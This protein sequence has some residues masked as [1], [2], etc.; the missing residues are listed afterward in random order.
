MGAGIAAVAA[1]VHHRVLLY[2][3]VEG[4]AAR[5]RDGIAAD[6]AALVAR[7]KLSEAEAARRLS[8]IEVVTDLSGLAPAELVIEAIIEDMAVL[9]KWYTYYNSKYYRLHLKFP[10][11]SL[12]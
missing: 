3:A 5:G 10:Y 12:K 7:G 6:W 8:R 11:F 4:A 9:H 1:G 2:D